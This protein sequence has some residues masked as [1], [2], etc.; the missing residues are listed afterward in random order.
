EKRASE[1]S[2]RGLLRRAP[3]GAGYLLPRAKAR[4][5]APAASSNGAPKAGA[6]KVKP[7]A[8]AKPSAAQAKGSATGAAKQRPLPAVLLDL[9]PGRGGTVSAQELAEGA[10]RAGYRS[11]SKDLKNVVW[12]AVRK[13]PG[14]ERDP[15]GGYRLKKRKA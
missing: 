8:P 4:E 2:R 1:L 13:V 12:G 6:A 15:K 14:V 7:A 10:G 9:Q 5:A 11:Q 3:G